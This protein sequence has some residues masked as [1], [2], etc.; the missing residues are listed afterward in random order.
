MQ[1]Q[2]QLTWRMRKTLVLWLVQ[3]TQEFG[4][5]QDTLFLAINL[6]DRI[7][8][9][10]S[11]MSSQ[12]QLLGLACLWIAAK[13]H[14]NHGRVPS[15]KKLIYICCQTYTWDNFVAMERFALIELGFYCQHVSSEEFL[16]IY[17][18]V[19]KLDQTVLSLSRYLIE[20]SMVHKRFIGVRSS[21]IARAAMNLA[22][23]FIHGY[24]LLESEATEQDHTCQAH[25]KDCLRQQPAILIKKVFQAPLICSLP[26][27]NSA[28]FPKLSKDMTL[29]LRSRFILILQIPF[30]KM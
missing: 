2:S 28:T 19:F 15:I 1:N 7:A 22:S 18:I 25:L 9:R 27:P 17:S 3:V 23:I 16:S 30:F 10:K 24:N 14:E 21:L 29:L 4:L 12:F 11:I 20:L 26:L 6:I 8:S 13:V 5:V